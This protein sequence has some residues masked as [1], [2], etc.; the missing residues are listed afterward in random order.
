MNSGTNSIST[1]NQNNLKSND[2]LRKVIQW[3]IRG[4]SNTKRTTLS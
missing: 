4:N 1:F 3:D 2:K